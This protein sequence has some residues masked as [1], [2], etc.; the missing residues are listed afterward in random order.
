MHDIT[1]QNLKKNR[2]AVIDIKPYPNTEENRQKI[3]K[4]L[5]SYSKK[6]SL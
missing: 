5:M 4:C 6:I 2:P 1:I 3:Q